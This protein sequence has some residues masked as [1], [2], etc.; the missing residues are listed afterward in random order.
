MPHRFAGEDRVEI[1]EIVPPQGMLNGGNVPQKKKKKKQTGMPPVAVELKPRCVRNLGRQDEGKRTDSLWILNGSTRLCGPAWE[2]HD[3][4]L[5][6]YRCG[7]HRGA[8]LQDQ[9]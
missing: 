5:L 8:A 3:T 6:P 7:K 1:N 9:R 2:D 4:H